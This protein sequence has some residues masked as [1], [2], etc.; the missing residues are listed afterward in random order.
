MDSGSLLSAE[1]V[2]AIDDLSLAAR[3]V[4]EGMRAGEHR[5]PFH[6]FNLEFSQY[7]EYRPGDD[8][9]YLDWKM[10]GRT[11]RLYTRQFLETTNMSVVFVLDASASMDFPQRVSKLRYGAILAAALA[12]LVIDSGDAAGLLAVSGEQRTWL[13]ARGGRAHL[14]LLLQRLARLEPAGRWQPADAVR[15]AAELLRRRGLLVVLSDFYDEED[16]TLSELKRAT[17]RGHEVAMLHLLSRDEVE[18]PYGGAL[19]FTDLE[20]GGRRVADA[21][22]VRDEYRARVAA[23]CDRLRDGAS[24]AGIDYRRFLTDEPPARALRQ[25]LVQRVAAAGVGHVRPHRK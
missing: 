4:V 18:L 16:G 13:P 2:A 9:K 10:L 6:G 11:D 23:F 1:V 22:K 14:Q 21:G 25:Y 17:A 20:G 19:E 15:R 12:R 24:G 5:S 3:R 7:R 8:L